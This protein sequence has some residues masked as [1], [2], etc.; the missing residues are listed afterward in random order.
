MRMSTF[1]DYMRSVILVYALLIT[2]IFIFV[3]IAE[4]RSYVFGVIAIIT[5]LFNGFQ[6]VKYKNTFL[7][8][9]KLDYALKKEPSMYYLSLAGFALG[10][11]SDSVEPLV[12]AVFV[13]CAMQNFKYIIMHFQ[14]AAKLKREL[15]N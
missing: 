6:Y 1:G 9:L 12:L 10:M 7:Y 4:T 14:L 2:I 3:D 13:A 8:R 5:L 15:Q 11:L